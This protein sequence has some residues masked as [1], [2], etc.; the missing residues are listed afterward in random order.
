[1]DLPSGI[2]PPS[3]SLHGSA[4]FDGDYGNDKADSRFDV[5]AH[6]GQPGTDCGPFRRSFDAFVASHGARDRVLPRLVC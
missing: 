5:S 2:L 4:L 1:M 3:M 6:D